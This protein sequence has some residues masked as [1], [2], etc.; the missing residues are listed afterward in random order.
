MHKLLLLLLLSTA[1]QAET[2]DYPITRV[3]DGDTV[4]FQAPFL[5]APLKPLLSIRVLGVDTPEKGHRAMCPEEAA[6]GEAAS[7]FTK[8]MVADSKKQQVTLVKW[9]KYGGRVLGDV[10]LDGKSLS[11]E[12]IK[13]GYARPYFGDKKE[14]WCK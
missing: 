12:L 14:S 10:I 13:Q 8:K 4:E 1:A 3:I 11:E 7:K 2:Y 5:P 9:D 6:L